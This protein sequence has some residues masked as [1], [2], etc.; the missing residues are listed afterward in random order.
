MMGEKGG[1]E[2]E[3]FASSAAA[4]ERT[5]EWRDE[6]RVK[7]LEGFIRRIILETAL[8]SPRGAVIASVVKVVGVVGRLLSFESTASLEIAREGF[9]G[10]WRGV[11]DARGRSKW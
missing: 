3:P 6:L 5:E 4:R 7:A 9:G 1:A 8:R 2:K 11:G 10:S